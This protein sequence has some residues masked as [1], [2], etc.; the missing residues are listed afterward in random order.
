MLINLEKW[1]RDNVED[2]LLKFIAAKNGR[3]QQGDQ[4]A[5][6]AILSRETYC[7]E[8][9]FNSVT[10]FYDFTYEEM[11]IYR[12]PSKFYTEDQVRVAVEEPMLIHFTTSFKSIRPWVRGCKHKYRDEWL[13]YK[14]MSPWKDAELWK[15]NRPV[16]KQR[17]LR[18]YNSL[19]NCIAVRLAG[20]MQVYGRPMRNR[21]RK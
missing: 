20:I 13:R 19:P 18:I 9:R 8:P 15:D 17:C 14:G 6:N 5:L 4:G 12:R 21:L 11:M 1:R 2:R 16:W 3:I 10:L 7:F